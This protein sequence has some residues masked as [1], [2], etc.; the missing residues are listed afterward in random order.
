[1]ILILAVGA[2]L[3]NGYMFLEN[4]HDKDLFLTILSIIGMLL[5]GAVIASQ[6]VRD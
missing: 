5:S 6:A 2:F 4:V 1:M 3:L